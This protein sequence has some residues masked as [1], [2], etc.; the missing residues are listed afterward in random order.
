MNNI[1]RPQEWPA[2]SRLSS[3]APIGIGTPMAE[4]LESF[5]CRL[6]QRHHV[7]RRA[8][9]Q[10]VN[11]H[12]EPL[13]LYAGG[14]PRL[15]SPTLLAQRFGQRLAE[16]TMRSDVAAL[17][18]GRFAERISSMHTLRNER[19]WCAQCFL[20]ARS[21]SK[22][23]YLPLVWSFT[24]YRLC[25]VH[26][27]VLDQKCPICNTTS[28][29][30]NSWS[31]AI[32]HCPCCNGDLARQDTN[33]DSPSM[34]ASEGRDVAVTM[35]CS[36]ILGEFVAEISAVTDPALPCKIDEE[37]ADAIHRG[38]A[39]HAGDFAAKAG[40]A[41]STLHCIQS[42]RNT[43]S[44]EALVRIVAMADISLA[45]LFYPLLRKQNVRGPA[46][47]G[48]R[49]AHKLRV[50]R[51][52]DW[53]QIRKET[54]KALAADHPISLRQLSSQLG[55]EQSYFTAHLKEFHQELLARGKEVVAARNRD[56]RKQLTD[57]VRQAR[58][59]LRHQGQRDTNRAIG[60]ALGMPVHSPN[61][62]YAL[63]ET[64]SES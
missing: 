30:S 44:L 3:M 33:G 8:I 64:K 61:M 11:R 60:R 57:K 35:H 21:A 43:A 25:H 10:T 5:T 59:S 56:Q 28:V 15:D 6:A 7:P 1:E 18:L 55:V 26:R 39:T 4:S 51:M 34:R 32:D 46:P 52:H 20:D 2:R 38:L 19:A 23:A 42:G 17:G 40:M 16:L 48:L 36:A 58:L 63:A 9:E 54:E 24:D 37:I 49:H 12:G 31:R 14:P 53:D 13:Y 22:P 29:A 45:G 62:R 41:K 27:R 50:R 47:P